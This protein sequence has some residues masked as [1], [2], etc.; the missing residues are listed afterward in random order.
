MHVCAATGSTLAQDA[1][2]LRVV[3]TT[4]DLAS[5][6]RAVA[7]EHVTLTVLTKGPEDPHF[8]EA[9]PSFIK[10][11]SEADAYLQNG[12]ELESGY[13]PALLQN[14]RNARVLPGG[15][16][17][18]DAS[19]AITPLEMPATAVDRSMG[20]VHALGNPHYLL[21]PV[22]ALQVT[23]LLE[24]RFARIR[25]AL[26]GV[27]RERHAAFRERIHKALVGE[28]LATK[29]DAGKLAQL[30]E[31]GK[32][33]AFLREQGDAGDL[34][35]WLGLIGAYRATRVVDDHRIW[36]YFAR[37]FG[38]EIFAD[39]EP[40]PGV[41]PTT[42][43]LAEIVRRMRANEV[44]IIVAAPYYDLRHAR[45]IAEATGATIVQLAHQ[46]GSREGTD[47]YVDMID[48]NVRQLAQALR[49]RQQNA[50]AGSPAR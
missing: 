22:R 37:R 33:D 12:L 4:P 15:S 1:A 8:A 17:Y 14:A 19:V 25:P 31:L 48:Y 13:A 44:G 34:G 9:K 39:L 18:I 28:V 7:G 49:H 27:L 30:F 10:A 36:P 40:L 43:H 11:L 47:D 41:P 29:Y 46:T 38:L 16:G 45:F 23:A 50:S 2:P 5:L 26:E 20:D 24:E 42:R 3:A 32:L 35:G 21:D 6:A